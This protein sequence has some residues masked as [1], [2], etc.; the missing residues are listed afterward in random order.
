MVFRH[1]EAADLVDRLPTTRATR[2]REGRKIPMIYSAAEL[3][4]VLDALDAEWLLFVA[5]MALAGL[6]KTEA[7]ELRAGDVDLDNEQL[8]VRGGEGGTKSGR[9]RIVPIVSSRLRAALVKAVEA[10]NGLRG[11][12][13]V[14][15]ADRQGYR[16]GGEGG[17]VTKVVSPHRLRHGFASLVHAGGVEQRGRRSARAGVVGAQHA[18]GDGVVYAPRAANRRGGCAVRPP[19]AGGAVGGVEVH[20]S[21]VTSMSPFRAASIHVWY[22]RTESARDNDAQ[23]THQ[24]AS[25]LGELSI[26]HVMPE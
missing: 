25:D 4:A 19:A 1:A 12:R 14:A 21:P 10:V 23:F 16:W 17:G 22:S 7:M 24:P 20:T 18:G 3:R 9:D 2:L 26:H 11:A 5:V 8:V 15:Q 13:L 6:R